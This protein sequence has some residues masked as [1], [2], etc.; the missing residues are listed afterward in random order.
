MYCDTP[1]RQ[2]RMFLLLG[3]V[4][5]KNCIL[6]EMKQLKF[7]KFKFSKI[8]ETVSPESSNQASMEIVLHFHFSTV[9]MS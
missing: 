1:P 4:E 8:L 6:L 5:A 2:F 3:I 7:A 9:D